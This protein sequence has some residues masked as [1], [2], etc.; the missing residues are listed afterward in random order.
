[1]S[2]RVSFFLLLLLIIYGLLFFTQEQYSSSADSNISPALPTS[3]LNV[4]GH[5]YMNQLIAE[6]LFIK[7]AVYQGGLKKEPGIENLEVMGQHFIAMS[8]LHPKMI[9]IYYRSES[10]LAHRGKAYVYTANQILET[11]REALPNE[12]ALPFLEGFNYFHYLNEPIK[13]GKVLRIG[14]EIPGAPQWIGHLA[15]M[16][17][18]SAGNIR[19]GL[20]WLKGMYANTQ[21]ENEKARYEKDILAFEKALQVQLALDRYVQKHQEYPEK[22]TA[23][24][25]A[26]LKALPIWE[27][28]YHLEYQPP[29]LSLRKEV[30][31]DDQ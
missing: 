19:T 31:H 20:I 21:D 23:L 30:P 10:T 1:M 26:D 9:D 8:Q 17:M 3:V 27:N 25:P 6:S 16:L 14:S 11:G 13:A 15:S 28:D 29:K 22:L 7:T 2:W 24:V 4:L 18:A 12:L 5:S